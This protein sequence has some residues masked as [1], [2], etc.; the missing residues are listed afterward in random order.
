MIP[1]P[2]VTVLASLCVLALPAPMPEN[3]QDKSKK[4]KAPTYVLL[5]NKNN[6]WQGKDVV[7]RALVRALFRKDKGVWSG[8]VK[9]RVFDRRANDPA[10]VAFLKNVLHISEK[11]LANHWLLQKQTKGSSA[12]RSI[13]SD[14][15]LMKMVGRYTGAFGFCKKPAKLPANVRILFEF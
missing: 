1:I 5:I 14:R 2:F 4:K 13:R 10:H 8:S 15:L 12:P 9:A 11:S 7:A 3:A 6:H